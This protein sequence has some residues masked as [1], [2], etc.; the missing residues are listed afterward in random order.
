MCD[1]TVGTVLPA[2]TFNALP[3]T[4]PPACGTDPAARL[5]TGFDFDPES[6]QIGADGTFWIGE[7]FG[8]FL[9]H[10]DQQGRL[11]EAPIGAPGVVSPQ[12]PTLDV[13][14]GKRPTVAQSRGFEGLAIS[15]SRRTLYAMTEGRSV[16]TTH[17]RCASGRSTLASG[18]SP[19]AISDCGSRCPVRRS[20]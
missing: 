3:A 14:A 9:L 13:L 2:F 5:L 10:A 18:C 12:N 19:A 16:R 8:P 17:R 7:E 15:P 11:L 20:T 1:P 6:V 4:P